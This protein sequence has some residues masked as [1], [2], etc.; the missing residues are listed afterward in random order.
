MAYSYDSL[1]ADD[2]MSASPNRSMS[3]SMSASPKPASN[4]PWIL[5]GL[6]LAAGVGYYFYSK[7]AAAKAATQAVAG[8]VVAPGLDKPKVTAAPPVVDTN[9]KVATPVV[10]TPPVVIATPPVVP[11]IPTLPTLSVP[12]TPAGVT[13]NESAPL[14]KM[15]LW[16]IFTMFPL[17]TTDGTFYT[18]S[19]T[20]ATTPSDSGA[21]F[22]MQKD[23]A[24]PGSVYVLMNPDNESLL[25]VDQGTAIAQAAGTS[26]SWTLYLKP[27]E[28]QS[29]A[30]AAAADSS[31]PAGGTPT[32]GQ[33]PAG[34]DPAA[35]QNYLESMILKA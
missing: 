8:K 30:A 14:N 17:T 28:W 18:L 1:S 27:G 7:D 4:L 11:A 24:S 3:T 29:V 22:I 9:V 2:S 23:Q 20:P 13:F 31:L 35:V 16:K 12:P 6:A 34:I 5:G 26:P 32:A 19:Q 33:A 15:A 10:T 25:F 21:S